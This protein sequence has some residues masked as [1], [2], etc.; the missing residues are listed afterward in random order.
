MFISYGDRRINLHLI[1]EY[2][3]LLEKNNNIIELIFIDNKK[4]NLNFFRNK[5]DRDNFL[6]KLDKFLNI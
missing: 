5:E 1:K 6:E 4:E 2:K 3:P